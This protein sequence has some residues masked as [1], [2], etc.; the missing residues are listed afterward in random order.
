MVDAL[1]VSDVHFPGTESPARDHHLDVGGI[2]IAVHEWG[3]ESADPLFLVHGGSDFG[4]TYDEFGPRL[5]RAGWRVITWDQR[6]HG[7][8]EH[9]SLYGWDADIRDAIGVIGHFSRRPA[10]VVGHSKGGALMIQLADAQP[11]RFSHLINLDGLPSRRPMS[12]VTEHERTRM[13][14]SDLGGWLDHRRS[15]ATAERKPGT[16]DELARRRARSNPRLPMEWLRYLVT[17][18]A[19]H[20]PDGWRWKLDP[21]IRFGGFG[22]WRPE[23]TATRLPGLGMPFLGVLAGQQ[24]PMGWGTNPAHIQPLLPPD[25]RLEVLHDAGHFVHIEQ[26]ERVAGMVLDF[27]NGRS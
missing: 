18:G 17:V 12:D 15:T 23:W 16:L 13:I 7:D 27:M 24:E 11:F 14:A 10:P 9:A 3:D 21:S 25:G 2:R 20:D 19:R 6:G 22:P 26:P 1:D 5:A 8:S 4:R